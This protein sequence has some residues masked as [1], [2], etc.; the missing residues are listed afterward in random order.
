[1][2]TTHSRPVR[3][4]KPSAP[5]GTKRKPLDKKLYCL[6]TTQRIPLA[7]RPKLWEEPHAESFWELFYDLIIV[8]AFIRLSSGKYNLT[9]AGLTTTSVLFLNFWSCWSMTNMYITSFAQ[10]DVFHRLYY[11][12][13][14]ALTFVMT[15]YLGHAEF[16]F[17]IFNVQARDF[18]LASIAIRV[19]TSIMWFHV[20]CKIPRGLS[21]AG[22]A[23]LRRSTLVK[24]VGLGASM[25]CFALVA[26]RAGQG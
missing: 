7:L 14:I 11:S 15:M 22:R 16:S 8:V 25:T 23:R 3:S 12:G 26:C 10:N 6:D 13:H 24:L 2:F 18:S 1:M 21:A 5:A 17:F 4:A 9:P 19:L 20:L